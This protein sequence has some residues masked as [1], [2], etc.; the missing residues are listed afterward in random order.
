MSLEAKPRIINRF[1]VL[2]AF[3]LVFFPGIAQE[4]TQE[5]KKAEEKAQPA[6]SPQVLET[7][8]VTARRRKEVLQDVPIAVSTYSAATLERENVSDITEIALSSPNTTL[9]ASRA[10]NSTLTAFIRG[11]GQQDPLAGFEPGVGIYVDDV[12]IARPQGTIFDV[13]DV[14]RLE[15]LRGPQGTLYG[16]N[17][18]GGALKYVTKRLASEKEFKVKLNAGTYNQADAILTGSAPIGD[19][20]KIGGTIA[21]FNR[22]GFGKNLFTGGE[23]YDKDVFGARVSME[24]LPTDSF[25]LKL[26]GDYTLD[27]SSP[28][29]GHRLIV[30]GYSGA[31]VLDNVFDTRAGAE[32][33]DTTAGINGNNEFEGKGI[34]LAMEYYLNATTTFKSV[35]AYREDYSESVIDFDSLPTP[36]FDAPV[37]Y[38][39]DQ[40]SQEFQVNYEGERLKG[41]FGFYYLDANAHNDFDVVLGLL[42]VTAYTGG[43]IGT[44]TWSLFTDFTYDVS[45]RLSLSAGG[46]YTNDERSA[47]ILRQT[48]LG[49]GSTIFGNESALLLATNGD[50]SAQRT[51]TD[52]TPRA[53]ISW[54]PTDTQHVFFTYSQGFKAGSFDPRGS[55]VLFPGVV[56]GYLPEFVDSYEVGVKSTW[57]GGRGITS[58]NLFA[59]DYTDQQIPGSVGIDTDGDGVQ[60]DFAGTVTNAGSSEMS[61]LEFEGTVLATNALTLHFSLGLIDAEIKEWI[62][63]GENI[64]DQRVFQNTPETTANFRFNYQWPLS[65]RNSTGSLNLMGAWSYKGDTYQFEIP[66]PEIDQDAYSL[67]DLGL[68]WTSDS[69]KT[70]FGIHGKNLGDEEYKVA[71]YYFPVLGLEGVI[72]PF[73]GNPLTVTATTTFRF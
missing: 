58:L 25:F 14:E 65:I 10:T 49:L 57:L 29:S 48:F 22:D 47:T 12:Y 69:G 45:D 62:F 68:V 7:I 64:A 38:D 3:S 32:V 28:K 18:I 44:K 1:I 6:E 41:I 8:T 35:T 9:E 16:R 55:E 66:T 20:V 36:D 52:F 72:S 21:K 15:I 50:F 37:I 13:Y 70:Q 60:D 27:K 26:S 59:N 34:S 51:Y 30:G 53:N 71:G 56:D 4:P 54:K 5:Q 46:R 61:G 67:F 31:E 63:N 73:Y 43:T 40:F 42:G 2:M 19:R 39:N 17:T 11:V 24:F 33:L 23:H